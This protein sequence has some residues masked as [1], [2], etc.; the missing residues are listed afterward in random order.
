MTDQPLYRAGAWSAFVAAGLTALLIGLAPDPAAARV[1][2]LYVAPNGSTSAD[3]TA[4]EQAVPTLT[5]AIEIAKQR[6]EPDVTAVEVHVAPGVY[7]G[8]QLKLLGTPGGLPLALV[9]P[10]GRDNARALFQG[11]GEGTWLSYSSNKHDRNSLKVS[12]FEVS[13]YRTAISLNG[14]RKNKNSWN[15]GHE[16]SN[17]I[18]MKI[19]Q[20]SEAVRPSTAAIRL[21]NSRNNKI[22]GNTFNEIRNVQQCNLLHAVYVAHYSSGNLI[23]N[24]TF[25]GGCGAVIK[26]R[27]ASNGNKIV[28]NKFLNQELEAV[29]DSFCDKSKSSMC[30]REAPECPSWDNLVESN[31]I[32]AAPPEVLAARTAA[33]GKKVGQPK[34]AV[35]KGQATPPGCDA[36]PGE[37]RRI[38][39]VQ[40][41]Y[42]KK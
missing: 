16:I 32:A 21:V 33:A 12:G 24:N 7:K 10:A 9:G 17:N 4:K 36:P 38:R 22:V 11:K 23:S 20:S 18:F 13:N 15:G 35:V 41:Q 26:V 28:Q 30:T 14:S 1:L 6:I 42:M 2:S 25:D 34:V 37:G 5:R 39:S 19:G 8:Q 29:Q 40:N 27:D 3:G 31:A